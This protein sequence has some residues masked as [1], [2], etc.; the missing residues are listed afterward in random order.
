MRQRGHSFMIGL[1]ILS[2]VVLSTLA[3]LFGGK[4]A[5]TLSYASF[6]AKKDIEY[7]EIHLDSFKSRM[8]DYCDRKSKTHSVSE[9]GGKLNLVINWPGVGKE[10][11]YNRNEEL[12]KKSIVVSNKNELSAE[13]TLKNGYVVV[14]T[15]ILYAIMK[16]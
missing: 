2:L 15:D 1:F 8:N 6:N 9:Q 3:F 13:L 7:L 14:P 11:F 16:Q 4:P 10:D 5:G 12:L